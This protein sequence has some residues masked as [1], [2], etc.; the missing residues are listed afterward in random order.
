VH[1]VLLK[2]GKNATEMYS[3]IKTAFGDNSLSPSVIL[4]GLNVSRMNNSQLKTIHILE[5]RRHPR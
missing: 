3:M 2:L 4:N 1:K 5:D